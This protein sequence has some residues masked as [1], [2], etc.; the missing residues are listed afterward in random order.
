MLNTLLTELLSYEHKTEDHKLT[1][2]QLL[3]NENIIKKLEEIKELN[4][5]GNE[6]KRLKDL[7]INH[8]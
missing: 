8:F 3:E 7:I 2:G 5:R 1:C 4:L 6:E